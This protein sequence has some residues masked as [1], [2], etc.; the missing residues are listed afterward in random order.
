MFPR[1]F[2]FKDKTKVEEDD[3]E[4]YK[5][6]GMVG[7]NGTRGGRRCRGCSKHLIRAGNRNLQRLPTFGNEWC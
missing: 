5:N 1:T 7:R 4:C 6:E 2:Y 3:G